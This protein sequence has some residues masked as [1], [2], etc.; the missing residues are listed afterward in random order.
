MANVKH[1]IETLIGSPGKLTYWLLEGLGIGELP[2]LIDVT[3]SDALVSGVA[4]SDALAH[5][6][7]LSDALVGGV[8]LSDVS[9]T[10]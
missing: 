4:L 2:P 7:A 9:R 10:T 5:G 6:V 1:I 8:T 3:L